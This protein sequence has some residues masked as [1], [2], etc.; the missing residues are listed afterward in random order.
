MTN[1]NNPESDRSNILCFQPPVTIRDS[2]GCPELT[3]PAAPDP[4][5]QEGLRLC[6]AYFAIE[7]AALRASLIALLEN[8]AGRDAAGAGLKRDGI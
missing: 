4:L 6:K 1:N 7:D 8:I 3:S 2:A 5:A